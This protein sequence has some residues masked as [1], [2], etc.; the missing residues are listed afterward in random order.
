ML[1]VLC[2]AAKVAVDCMLPL[3]IIDSN[4]W[5]SKVPIKVSSSNELF[6][7]LELHDFFRE[8]HRLLFE[9]HN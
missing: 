7:C 3:C 5:P 2:C 4:R 6:F 1:D 9:P 8:L